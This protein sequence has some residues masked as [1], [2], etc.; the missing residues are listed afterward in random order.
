MNLN[1]EMFA[2]KICELEQQYELMQ[3]RLQI[4]R[5]ENHEE[6]RRELAR[7]LAEYREAQELMEQRKKNSRSPGAAALSGICLD[8]FRQADAIADRELPGYL[9]SGFSDGMQDRADAQALYAEYAIDVAVQ[10]MR[11]AVIAVMRAMDAQMDCDE[12]RTEEPAE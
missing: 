8:Y 2:V 12:K 6:I 4:C 11:H 9:H 10:S 7:L 1:Q 5:K 3:S